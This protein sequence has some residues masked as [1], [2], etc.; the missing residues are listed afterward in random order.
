[1][2]PQTTLFE[3]S[4]DTLVYIY[5]YKKIILY[6]HGIYNKNEKYYIN[7]FVLNCACLLYITIIII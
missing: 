7:G 1:M 4:N 2:L 6:K 5:I 3:F